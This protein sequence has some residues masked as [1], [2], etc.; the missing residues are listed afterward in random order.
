MNHR[1]P[2]LI[3]SCL[4]ILFG[5][6][7]AGAASSQATPAEQPAP[8]DVRLSGR[9][10]TWDGKPIVG[11]AVRYEDAAASTTAELLRAPHTVTDASGG[12]SFVVQGLRHND[13]VVRQL[14]VAAKGMAAIRRA[15]AWQRKGT[16]RKPGGEVDD[17]LF[18]RL[19]SWRASTAK[20]AGVPPYV[21]FHDATLS[22]IAAAQPT[23]LDALGGISG[24]G[25]KKLERYGE[26]IL[27]VVRSAPS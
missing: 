27:G 11:A 3:R 12:F 7:I 17:A 19:R 16:E 21:I 15:V 5:L 4:A 8:K 18:E 13:P 20:S 2:E 14:T 24:I 25:A 9:V 22:A 26:E 6:F 1:S 10:V 23:T